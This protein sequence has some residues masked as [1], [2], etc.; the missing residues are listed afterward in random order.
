MEVDAWAEAGYPQ[1]VRAIP[2]G[3]ACA[4]CRSVEEA[5]VA[6]AE[7]EFHAAIVSEWFPSTRDGVDLAREL[8][9]AHPALAI[10]M[11]AVPER[12]H[13]I[14]PAIRAGVRGYLLKEPGMRRLPRTVRQALTR[15]MGEFSSPLTDELLAELIEQ[16]PKFVK[17]EV[18]S[19]ER[20]V[21][22]LVGRGLSNQEIA[23][24]LDI[25]VATVKT[26]VHSAM[27]KTGVTNRVQLALRGRSP[28]T[29]QGGR[30]RR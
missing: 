21:V 17:M 5:L 26:H 29:R 16:D 13:E 27:R 9:R 25:T 19:R 30:D 14:L 4:R 6:A 8:H 10:I 20:D 12:R 11:V 24:Q 2:Q 3:G 7:V 1:G 18:T 22:E 23:E 15:G 28:T